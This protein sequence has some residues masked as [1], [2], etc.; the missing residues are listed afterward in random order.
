MPSPAVARRPALLRGLAGAAALLLIPAAAGDAGAQSAP[1]AATPAPDL[2]A[3]PLPGTATA[4]RG[5]LQLLLQEHTYLAGNTTD[6]L[7]GGRE[8]EAGAAG[9]ALNLNSSA[10]SR[11]VGSLFGAGPEAR[12]VE[13]WSR[14][15]DDYRRYALG[16]LSGSD[17]QRQEAR[18]DLDAFVPVLAGL[19]RETVPALPDGALTAAL[20]MHVRGTLDVIDAQAARDYARVFALSRDGATMA[21]TDLGD[22]LAVAIAQQLPER[23]PAAA[24]AAAAGSAEAPNSPLGARL[25]F[26]HHVFLAS[27]RLETLVGGRPDALAGVTAALTTN[28]QQ[29]VARVQAG[30]GAPAGDRFAAVWRQHLDAF[31]AYAGAAARGD[32]SGRSEPAATLARLAQE[33]DAVL[34]AGPGGAAVRGQIADRLAPHVAYALKAI[35]ALAAHDPG[36]AYGLTGGAARQVDEIALRVAQALGPAPAA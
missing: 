36:T 12:F 2:G 3:E 30:L 22:P 18:A 26:Q 19:L 11:K 9:A 29:L 31:D 33:L 20:T 21:A 13:Q 17:A 15:I 35:D 32:A 16:H 4:L 25:L 7:L 8:A 10:L 27:T 23:F 6:A 1:P 14:H 24:D 5:E 28:S 34:T